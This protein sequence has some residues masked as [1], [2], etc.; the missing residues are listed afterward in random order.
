MAIGSAVKNVST[1]I[2]AVLRIFVDVVVFWKKPIQKGRESQKNYVKSVF[3]SFKHLFYF[4]KVL[5]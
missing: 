1:E 3:E 2:N 4:S 5:I